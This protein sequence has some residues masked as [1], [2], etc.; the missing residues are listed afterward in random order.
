MLGLFGGN[1]KKPQPPAIAGE[2]KNRREVE[3]MRQEN[4]I[5]KGIQS[6]MPDPY[7]V[8]DMDYNIILC[9]KRLSS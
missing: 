2:A 1:D 7:Y 8:R 3:R 6:A 4:A 5:L 9:P